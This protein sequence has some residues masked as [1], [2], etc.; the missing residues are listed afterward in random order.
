[1]VCGDIQCRFFIALTFL[2]SWRDGFC[3]FFFMWFPTSFVSLSNRLLILKFVHS[4][5][6][7]F[8]AALPSTRQGMHPLISLGTLK[9][10][11]MNLLRDSSCYRVSPKLQT[12]PDFSMQSDLMRQRNLSQEDKKTHSLQVATWRQPFL[13]FVPEFFF[14]TAMQLI[15]LK[16]LVQRRESWNGRN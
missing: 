4:H 12:S 5:P 13:L 8:P 1:M 2:K 3:C 9:L 14:A 10:R 15:K 16:F 11:R 6:S 7:S